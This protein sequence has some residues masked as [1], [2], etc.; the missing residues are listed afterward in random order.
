[1]HR[2][3][4]YVGEDLLGDGLLK[5][6]FV[7]ALRQ[8]FPNSHITWIAGDKE[9]VYGTMLAPCVEGLLNKV[10][11][12]G[13]QK[14]DLGPFDLLIDTQQ[15]VRVTLWL[16]DIPHQVFISRTWG[17]FWSHEA[18]PFFQ[19]W[20]KPIHLCDQ[21]LQLGALAAGHDLPKILES[22]ELP[23]TYTKPVKAVLPG[24]KPYIGL[25]P[26]AGQDKKCWPLDHFIQVAKEQMELGRIPVFILGPKEQPW[27][28]LLKKILPEA[29][30]PLQDHPELLASPLY[31]IALA[32]KFKVA[33]ANDSGTGHLFGAAGIPLVS[34]FGPTNPAKLH[35]LTKKLAVLRA[36][37][38]KDMKSLTVDQVLDTVEKL[39]S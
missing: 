29:L 6:P 21:L 33:I 2:I 17:F 13:R 20:D 16:R 4:I 24:Q 7:R 14:A 19:R 15:D 5:L 22:L 36:P 11:H 12:Q 32:Q 9:S 26:G 28:K 8:T 3:G 1:M 38:P 31:T 27:H 25:A 34:L 10:V 39:L 23:N 37:D 18:P 35:P 30:F